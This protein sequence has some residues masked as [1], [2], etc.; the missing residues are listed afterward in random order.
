M[1]CQLGDLAIQ[2][3]SRSGNEGRIVKVVKW[4]GVRNFTNGTHDE[5]WLCEAPNV[6]PNYFFPAGHY[7][8]P[9]AW[10]RPVS[11]LPEAYEYIGFEECKL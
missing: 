10:I 5:C 2:I 7:A 1:N 8:I 4:Y 6:Q 3:S 9:D 11:G